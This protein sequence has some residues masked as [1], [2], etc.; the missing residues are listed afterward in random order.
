MTLHELRVAI[1]PLVIFVSGLSLAQT[2]IVPA[3]SAPPRARK[4]VVDLPEDGGTVGCLTY[5]YTPG[6][7]NPS[8][9]ATTNGKCAQAVAIANQDVAIDNGWN[10]GGIP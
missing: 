8:G 3:P 4:L 6:G 7:V 2:C 10:D 1:I 9:H 5:G